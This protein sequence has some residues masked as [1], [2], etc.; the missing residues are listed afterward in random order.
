MLNAFSGTWRRQ[1]GTG[2]CLRSLKHS[3]DSQIIVVDADPVRLEKLTKEF[4]DERISIIKADLQDSDELSYVI[5]G[6]DVAISCVSYKFNYNLAK[7]AIEAGTSFCD[8]GGNEDVVRKQFLLDEMAREKELA[9]IPD[10]GLAPGMVSVLAASAYNDLEETTE[11]K[12]RV[13]GLPVEPRPPLNYAQFFSVEGL[14][15]EYVE[16]STIIK[17]G[18]LLRVPSLTEVE[19]IIFPQPFGIMEAFHT[20]GGISTLPSTLGSNVK[21]LDY[22]TIR[23]PGHCEKMRLLKEL[24]LMSSASLSGMQQVSPRQ[25]LTELLEQKLPR[26]EP[27]VVLIRVEA[28]GMKKGLQTE[29]TWEAIDY[30]DEPNR[31]SAMMR[32]TAFPISIIAQMIANDEI[33]DRGALYQELSIPRARFLEEMSKRGVQLSRTEKTLVTTAT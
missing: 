24:G 8:L 17:D 16:D 18:R 21:N 6:V 23:Y 29:I 30:M 3:P 2:G 9:I 33:K 19:E 25:V 32:T 26:E 10:C 22:K 1:D 20:S 5:S 12:I 31:L 15:N 28:R 7:A 4:P 11:I 13:G 27:D 14:L